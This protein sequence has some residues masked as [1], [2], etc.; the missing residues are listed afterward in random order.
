M[1]ETA[2][3][4]IPRSAGGRSAMDVALDAASAAGEIIRRG[5]RSSRQITFKGRKDIV[6]DVDV[7][8][9]NAVLEILSNA[10]PAFGILAEE[11]QP[12]A[13][14][15]ESSSP[16]TWVVDPLDGT[17]NYAQGIPHFS[18]VVALMHEDTPVLGVTYDPVR[19]ELFSAQLGC[20]AFLN[21]QPLAVSQTAELSQ[22]LL[23]CDLGYVDER[24]GQ[25][26]D[27]VR[28]LWPGILTLRLMGSAALG[29]AYAA[30]GRLDLYFHHSL[31]PWD[32][33]AGL[34]LVRE[35]GGAIVDK[36]G[37]P[38]GLHT[39]SVIAANP[40]LVSEFLKATDG[41]PWRT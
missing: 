41:L 13:Q 40:G 22:S 6:T 29:L 28:S 17:R 20:G 8:A 30:A 33:A 11:S 4:P 36:R 19:E 10:F 7:D 18:T 35:A 31:A 5:W 27:L 38:A 9:E 3:D 23:G 34:V 32:I 16:Y 39:P 12:V 37:Q 14:S 24:A 26:I 25:A 1:T 2:D 21:G 15:V